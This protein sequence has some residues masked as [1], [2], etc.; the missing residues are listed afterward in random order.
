[1]S[2]HSSEAP[3]GTFTNPQATKYGP[4]YRPVSI[5]EDFSRTV[6]DAYHVIGEKSWEVKTQVQTKTQNWHQWFREVLSCTN[7]ALGKEPRVNCRICYFEPASTVEAPCGHVTTCANCKKSYKSPKCM[8]CGT[9]STLRVDISS[10]LGPGPAHRPPLC[11]LCKDREVNV[12]VS[13]CG[14]LSSC[15]QCYQPYHKGCPKCGERVIERTEIL[16]NDDGLVHPGRMEE[17][18]YGAPQSRRRSSMDRLLHRN[19]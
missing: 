5:G 7:V 15:S 9:Y 12:L 2:V 8:V 14:H 17:D 11:Y 13:P 18:G 1:M 3:L 6:D 4:A 10:M 19:P 16:W